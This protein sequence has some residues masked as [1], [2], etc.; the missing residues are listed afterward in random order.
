MGK[1]KVVISNAH[2]PGTDELKRAI[3]HILT[4]MLNKHN[5][6]PFVGQMIHVYDED[7]CEITFVSYC[8]EYIHKTDYWSYVEDALEEGVNGIKRISDTNIKIDGDYVVEQPVINVQ[9]KIA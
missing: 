6:A 9:F 3:C 1:T 7:I 4:Y 8:C 2:E 5:Q